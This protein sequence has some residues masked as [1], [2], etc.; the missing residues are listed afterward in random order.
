MNK[1]VVVTGLGVL[2][3]LGDNK[4]QFWGSL[5]EG[6][7]GVSEIE[8]FDISEYPTKIAAE[9]KG[10]DPESYGLD[11]KEARRM[12]RFVQL[13]V[14]ASL[15][16]VEDAGL[17]IGE[18][19]D[20]ERTGVMVGS[21]IGGLGTWEDQHSV[22]LEKGPKRVSPFFIPMMIANMASGQVSMATG[23]KGPNTTVVTGEPLR[24]PPRLVPV[25]LEQ[26]AESFGI[27]RA[28]PLREL[29]FLSRGTSRLCSPYCHCNSHPLFFGNVPHADLLA[30][31]R[32]NQR[33]AIPAANLNNIRKKKSAPQLF[34]RLDQLLDGLCDPLF[35]Q[36]GIAEPDSGIHLP[37]RI[38][39]AAGHKGDRSR[40]ASLEQQIGRDSVRQRNPQVKPS[41]R[42]VPAPPCP[43]KRFFHDILAHADCGSQL[44]DMLLHAAREK[45]MLEY[46][47]VQQRRS[48]V[49]QRLQRPDSLHDRRTRGK[50]GNPQ[51]GSDIFAEAADIDD[52]SLRIVIE[53]RRR[54]G[55]V[56]VDIMIDIILHQDAVM[57]LRQL[58]QQ[59]ALLRRHRIARR[60]VEG[61]VHIEQAR[62]LL[63]H[64]RFDSVQII[65]FRRQLDRQQNDVLLLEDVDCRT[66]CWPFDQ[67]SVAGLDQRARHEIDRL[68]RPRRDE[69]LSGIDIDSMGFGKKSG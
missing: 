65:S 62:L 16:A 20:A 51:A 59:L 54:R 61:R 47:L 22:L 9:I 13:A 23:A 33:D 6:K 24:Q 36:K 19:S 49:G 50:H 69:Q 40:Q 48:A 45:V 52:I 27:S 66:I 35:A 41:V 34:S 11:R 12:D 28:S 63:L 43:G 31:L 17:R 15:K 37:Q 2:T 4:E 39:D 64:Q 67:D 5:M 7:S 21:G 53:Q 68:L 1:R 32:P 57:A 56:E 38:A 44:L 3:A 42:A 29:Q 18:N 10:F 8:S 26:L 60:I 46:F 25:P 14:V 30:S 58:H 55:L